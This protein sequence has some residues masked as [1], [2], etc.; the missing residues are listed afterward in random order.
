[1]PVSDS[2]HGHGVNSAFRIFQAVRELT[3]MAIRQDLDNPIGRANHLIA[4]VNHQQS[5][6][7]IESE[8]GQIGFTGPSFLN[9]ED[10]LAK[11]TYTFKKGMPGFI[12]LEA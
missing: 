11:H 2:R 1:M 6:R 4:V 9:L 10:C 7:N 3:V 5:F 8:L 12:F